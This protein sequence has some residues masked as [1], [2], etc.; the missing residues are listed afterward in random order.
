MR[1]MRQFWEAFKVTSG[2]K[3]VGLPQE[4]QTVVLF[5]LLGN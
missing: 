4:S 1:T 3:V 2:W 5:N